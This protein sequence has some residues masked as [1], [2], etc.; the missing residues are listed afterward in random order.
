MSC[1]QV[2]MRWLWL[3]WRTCCVQGGLPCSAALRPWK[4]S[5]DPSQA[6]KDTLL[7]TYCTNGGFHHGPDEE[8]SSGTHPCRRARD[9]QRA[10]RRQNGPPGKETLIMKRFACVAL[11]SLVLMSAEY[12]CAAGADL[13]APSWRAGKGLDA[14]RALPLTPFYA[15]PALQTPAPPG[16]LVRAEPATDYTLPPGV[17]ATRILYHTRTADNN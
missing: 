15:S 13:F 10:A 3:P 7:V 2:K 6:W 8:R 5:C 4:R 12:V 14:E 9:P 1:N 16:T 11:T 17:T